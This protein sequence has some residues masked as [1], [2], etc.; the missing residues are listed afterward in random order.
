M[1]SLRKSRDK[2]R[3]DFAPLNPPNGGF[4]AF[5]LIIFSILLIAYRLIAKIAL[6][7]S[8]VNKM[9]SVLDELYQLH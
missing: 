5:C 3:H 6:H 9:L 7:L 1:S 8:C 2:E 4:F